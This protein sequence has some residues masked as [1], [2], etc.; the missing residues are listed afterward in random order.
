AEQRDADADVAARGAMTVRRDRCRLLERSG[1]QTHD[2]KRHVGRGAK[3]E[4]YR[5]PAPV[6]FAGRLRQPVR[7][8]D[9]I[10]GGGIRVNRVGQPAWTTRPFLTT[11][12]M[13]SAPTRMRSIA[14]PRTTTASICLPGS[15][16]PTRSWRSSEYAALIVAPTS[17]SSNVRFIPKHASA[18]ANGIDGE[19]PP[20]GLMSVAS[21]TGTPR[22]ISMRPGANR[23]SFK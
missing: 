13:V 11:A 19:R 20:P 21:A 7:G 22:S 5:R 23:P 18:I 16:L 14:G 1:R 17:A 3:R 2:A 8:D 12:R 10:V 4:L 6:E 15:R 9:L